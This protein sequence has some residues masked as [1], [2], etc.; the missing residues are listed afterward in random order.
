[1]LFKVFFLLFILKLAPCER[2]LAHT[3]NRF[4]NADILQFTTFLKRRIAN[5]RNAFGNS[6]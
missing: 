6:D 2:I 3:R 1:M 4:G 5:A